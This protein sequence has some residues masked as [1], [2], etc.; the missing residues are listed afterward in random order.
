MQQEGRPIQLPNA[1]RVLIDLTQNST[2]PQYAIPAPNY[3]LACPNGADVVLIRPNSY[4]D[5]FDN[6]WKDPRNQIVDPDTIQQDFSRLDV[7]LPQLT[8]FK[9]FRILP[10]FHSD[11]PVTALIDLLRCLGKRTTIEQL[12]I[13]SLPLL[14]KTKTTLVFSNLRLLYIGEIRVVTADGLDV[15]AG[16]A[17]IQLYAPELISFHSGKL[18]RHFASA[19][20]IGIEH[21]NS[22]RQ[23][24]HLPISRRK[25]NRPRL[26]RH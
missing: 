11:L 16:V 24:N 10:R 12:E 3:L 5:Q 6:R 22:R 21:L 8:R 13:D 26:S 23:S 19:F 17:G 4:D 25:K 1:D 2:H 20:C 14:E 18:C 7:H 15:P 9:T